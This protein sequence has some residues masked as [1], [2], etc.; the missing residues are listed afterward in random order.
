M[1][2]EL[3]VHATV[4]GYTPLDLK[5]N[6]DMVERFNKMKTRYRSRLEQERERSIRLRPLKTSDQFDA[7]Q[8][9]R[10]RHFDTKKRLNNFGKTVTRIYH[11]RYRWYRNYSKNISAR[12]KKFRSF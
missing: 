9:S 11:R 8:F 1:N 10:D 4:H 5:S 7:T 12:L 6:Q 2:F 3:P